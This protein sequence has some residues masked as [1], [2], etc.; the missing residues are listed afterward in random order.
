[1]QSRAIIV[2]EILKE[3]GLYTGK[4]DG[5]F[6]PKSEAALNKYPGLDLSWPL[7]RKMIGCMQLACKAEKIEVGTIDGRWGPSTATGVEAYLHLK[8]NKALPDL[9]RPEDIVT[10]KPNVWPKS[11]TPQFDAFFGPVGESNLVR[12]NFPYPMKLAWAP[13]SKVTSTRCHKK[14][15][16]SAA[17]VLSAVLAH[18]GQAKISEL[19][20]DVFG[21]CYN[22]RAIR[23]GSK[24]S[25][26]SWG[27]AFD[28]DP[29]RNQLKWGRDKAS[30]AKPEYNAWWQAWEAEGWTSLG[31]ERNFD[32]MHVQAGGI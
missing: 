3:K 15:A 32:W 10:T 5:D 22:L 23:G 13:Y 16:D 28:F 19:K 7:E 21:G 26:H 14:V 4:I 27:V 6:G 11:Y 8:E 18:Y 20:L 12:L 9:W 31:R 2:Q 29:G 25:M 1:M 30:F 24:P 17:R